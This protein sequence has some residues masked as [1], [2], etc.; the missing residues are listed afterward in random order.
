MAMHKRVARVFFER[1]GLPVAKGI[2]VERG[3]AKAAARRGRAEVGARLV[4]KPSSHGSAIGVARLEAEAS[5]DEV[6]QAIEA[7]WAIDDVVII[8]HFARGRELT[9]GVLDVEGPQALPP[10]EIRSPHDAFYNY[11][12]KYAPGRSQ[13]VCPADLPAQLIARVQSVALG[14]HAALGCRDL[15]RVDIIVGDDGREDELTLLEVNTLPGMTATSLFPEAAAVA[16]WPMPKW[17]DAL[18]AKAHVRGPTRR[19]EPKPLPR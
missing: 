12:A 4:V 14:A 11:E 15:S 17:C 5:E 10:T 1:A 3:D 8:E 16:G 19:L 6:A 7:A 9:C 18:V 13:H 2:A